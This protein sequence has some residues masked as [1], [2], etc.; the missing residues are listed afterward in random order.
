[1]Y[2]CN[3][4]LCNNN[5]GMAMLQDVFF[6]LQATSVCLQ[7]GV[8]IVSFKVEVPNAI[9]QHGNLGVVF[10]KRCPALP[11]ARDSS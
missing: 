2:F 5:V 8:K 6:N 9:Q 3:V 1:M 4:A 10:A 11:T 7:C